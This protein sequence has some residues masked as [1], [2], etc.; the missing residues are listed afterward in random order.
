MEGKLQSFSELNPNELSAYYFYVKY[1]LQRDIEISRRSGIKISTLVSAKK[2]LTE[3]GLLTF[4]AFPFYT[5]DGF[6]LFSI[7][8]VRVKGSAEGEIHERLREINSSGNVKVLFALS[9]IDTAVALFYAR[10]YSDVFETKKSLFEY[11]STLGNTLRIYDYT[12]LTSGMLVLNLF[13]YSPKVHHLLKERCPE[14]P[15]S[16]ALEE[17]LKEMGDNECFTV[18]E[19]SG[20]N[21]D[22]KE[23]AKHLFLNPTATSVELSR[24][25]NM[26]RQRISRVRKKI[27]E[28]A[29]LRTYVSPF[30]GEFFEDIFT[31]YI[32]EFGVNVGREEMLSFYERNRTLLKEHNMLFLHSSD[33]AFILNNYPNYYTYKES[34]FAILEA[35][36][37]EFSNLVK[38]DEY[39]ISTKKR[40]TYRLPH[41]FSSLM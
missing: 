40:F 3:R 20:T 17:D 15:Q 35:L 22:V 34:K 26:S 36:K 8:V 28:E 31:F 41:H 38:M 33:H 21:E 39:F 30:E 24:H 11:Y 32:I 18:G 13:D 25:L 7:I 14:S 5:Y 12:L 27:V 23:V 10:R 4:R 29:L 9:D 19:D 1:P 2:R 37:R 6:N 16:V